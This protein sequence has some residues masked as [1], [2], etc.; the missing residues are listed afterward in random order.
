[1]TNTLSCK[2]GQCLCT[3]HSGPAAF[4]GAIQEPRPH[5]GSSR[6]KQLV[7]FSPAG[8]LSTRPASTRWSGWNPSQQAAVLDPSAAKFLFDRK[9]VCGNERPFLNRRVV[10]TGIIAAPATA[11]PHCLT[12]EPAGVPHPGLRAAEHQ[13]LQGWHGARRKKLVTAVRGLL[14]RPAA[15]SKTSG[16]VHRRDVLLSDFVQ[17]AV[18]RSVPSDPCPRRCLC[19]SQLRTT[20]SAPHHP[21]SSASVAGLFAPPMVNS[22]SQR[23]TARAACVPCCPPTVTPGNHRRQNPWSQILG[24]CPTRCW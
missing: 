12:G 4:R 24:A 23:R 5:H 9:A 22:P 15:R 13:N 21:P 19:V 17:L 8:R 20:G 1:M 7:R 3:T 18:G 6:A 10:S 2:S 14:R 16:G 11:S